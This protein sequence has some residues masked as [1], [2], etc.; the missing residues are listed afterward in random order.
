MII[1]GNCVCATTIV[2]TAF[3]LLTAADIR[4]QGADGPETAGRVV[5]EI[6]VTAQRRSE[7][8]QDVPIAMTAV[9][10]ADINDSGLNEVA[11]LQMLVP[12][13][14]VGTLLNSTAITI[15]GVGLN[16]GTPGVAIHTDGVFQPRPGM[17]DL[18]QVDLER[19]EVLRGPQGTL[20]GRNANGGA[21][22]F[23]TR[24]PERTFSSYLL[25]SYA[26]YDETR[27]QAMVNV[28]VTDRVAART[29]LDYWKRG[30]GFVKNVGDGPDLDRGETYSG[31]FRLA[32]ELADAVS[33]D[34]KIE[35]LRQT[36]PVSYFTLYNEPTPEAVALNPY[37]VD[38]VVPLE[39]WRTSAT[40]P[41]NSKRRYWS[42]SATLRWSL[43]FGEFK[44]ISAYTSFDDR[45]QTDSDATNLPAFPQTNDNQA[46]TLTQEFSLSG[47]GDKLDWVTGIYYM[48][49]QAETWLYYDFDLGIAPLPPMTYL[50]FDVSRYDTEAWAVFADFTY[51]L[52]E[53]LSLIA[54]ARYS[55]EDQIATQHTVAGLNLPD[56]SQLPLFELCPP[57]VNEPDYS[58][59]TPRGGFQYELDERQNVYFTISQGFKAGGINSSACANPFEPEEITA[60]E[61]GYKARL[62][63]ERLTL[64][65][66]AF[67]YDYTDLQLSQVVGLSSLVTNAAK[68]E[69]TG[70]EI[71][72]FWVPNDH[73]T[74][75]ANATLLDATFEEFLNV[76]SLN[77]AAGPQDVSGNQ[78]AAAPEESLNLNVSYFTEPFTWGTLTAR[79]GVSYRSE[80]Y[81]RE[82]N[83]PEDRQGAYTVLDL[84]L[85]WTSPD[86]RYRARLFGDNV[87]DEAYI[88][89]M[90]SSDNF[91]ARFV[92]WS[93]RRQVGLEI[94]ASF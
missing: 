84:A 36:G 69:V 39:P 28:P 14:Q 93:P 66:A 88:V 87:T 80:Q 24:A 94:R 81:F 43:P 33:L 74:V 68:A 60:Y 11:D 15:R 18:L 77:P 9:R 67:Y 50:S 78:L 22:N 47:G 62:A 91:G 2:A 7:S 44:S 41:S 59:F 51:Q 27:L 82:F 4:A 63:D 20:Y 46:K 83:D 1:K 19:V 31:R 30:E 52:T 13:M 25:G 79:A 21:V 26:S 40:D 38:A 8:I 53:R 35:G 90:G 56:G 49:D 57:T 12:S 42:T 6:V 54:G 55:R 73:W 89:R 85:I 29:V 10:G 58:S 86:E 23:I 32:A 72:A 5:E 48:D 17:G 61:A 70:V 65:V 76:D 64:N 92:S 71:E 3:G 75:N 45:F 34:W 37:L 16:Q